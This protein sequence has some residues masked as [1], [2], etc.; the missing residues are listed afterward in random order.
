MKKFKN[1]AGF[2]LIELVVIIVILGI[3]A[4]VAVPRY[5]NI[6]AEAEKGVATGVTGALRGSIAITKK[7]AGR[8]RR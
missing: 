3:L 1:E 4:V 5:L 8:V 7:N 2:T 6:T